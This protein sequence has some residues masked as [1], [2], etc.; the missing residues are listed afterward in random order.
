MDC[1]KSVVF[2]KDSPCLC[3][4]YEDVAGKWKSE[5][6]RYR[7][8]N[9]G[10]S[11]YV[12]IEPARAHNRSLS[13]NQRDQNLELFFGNLELTPPISRLGEGQIIESC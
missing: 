1:S 9:P 10:Q 7:R 3:I 2:V 6:T 5:N 12:K 4:H 13:L 8:H 11:L